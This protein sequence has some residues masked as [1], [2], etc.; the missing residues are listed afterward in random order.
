MALK[1]KEFSRSGLFN[2]ALSFHPDP[3]GLIIITIFY[4]VFYNVAW[5]NKR[6][7]DDSLYRLSELQ[8]VCITESMPV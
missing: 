2:G 5:L 8:N 3:G 7:F 4:N 1:I 6:E